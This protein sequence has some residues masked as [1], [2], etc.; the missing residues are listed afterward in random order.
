MGRTLTNLP[1]EREILDLAKLFLGIIS[2]EIIESPLKPFVLQCYV[3]A[4]TM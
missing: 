1:R 3:L 4:A 2:R